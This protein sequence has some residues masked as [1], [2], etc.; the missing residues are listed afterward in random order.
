MEPRTKGRSM[1]G[2][3]AAFLGPAL[4]RPA[5]LW[6]GGYTVG[7]SWGDRWAFLGDCCAFSCAFLG[8]F[9]NPCNLV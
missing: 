2:R 1:Q 6:N 3:L 4:A 8:R 9:M 5:G 7:P